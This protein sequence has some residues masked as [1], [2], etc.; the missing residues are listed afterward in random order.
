MSGIA[1]DS[2]RVYTTSAMK[3]STLIRTVAE[4]YRGR[5]GDVGKS[6]VPVEVVEANWSD[7]SSFLY[8]DKARQ[9]V[10]AV[11]PSLAPTVLGLVVDVHLKQKSGMREVEYK[12]PMNKFHYDGNQDV[13]EFS[14]SKRQA[15]LADYINSQFAGYDTKE[16]VDLR[17]SGGVV[18]FINL[19]M[20]AL[21]VETAHIHFPVNPFPNIDAANSYL[22]YAQ[23]HDRNAM[24]IA[25]NM[26]L[27]N[28]AKS[29]GAVTM[30]SLV[31]WFLYHYG[32]GV[33]ID[34]RESDPL[35]QLHQMGGG[36][37]GAMVETIEQLIESIDQP[38][39]I[40]KRGTRI[41]NTIPLR[42]I[43]TS[44]LAMSPWQGAVVIAN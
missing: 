29:S 26:D 12:T 11:A 22:E 32:M 40:G 20:L 13:M 31:E 3:A 10:A 9:I 34:H 43:A 8:R 42:P 19:G 38:N 4:Q 16:P 15:L 41:K 14:L 1:I 35:K 36:F 2:W 17:A 37:T 28:N 21:I 7:D 44:T 23:K 5:I 30:R 39:K 6:L 18:P 33:T 25:N 27:R 24:G